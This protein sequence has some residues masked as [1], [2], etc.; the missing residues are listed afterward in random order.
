M[1]ANQLKHQAKK[2][3]MYRGHT[4][5]A[6]ET[7]GEGEYKATCRCGM[8]VW[9]IVDPAPDEVDIGGEAVSLT[10]WGDRA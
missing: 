5:G 8:S 6:W 4:L 9:V 3:A 2:S 10:H 7:L 1:N